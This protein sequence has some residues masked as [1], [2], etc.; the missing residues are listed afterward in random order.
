M[1][2]VNKDF[3]VKNGVV[4]GANIQ[5]VQLVSTTSSLPPL[6]VTSSANVVNLSADLLDG[7]HGSY[8]L[9][10]NNATNIPDPV[11]GLE[12]TG[13]VTGAA[14]V[15]LT[16]LANGQITLN[17]TIGPD[18]IVLGTDTQGN[19]IAG[20]SGGTGVSVSSSA[21]EGVITGIS[22]GQDVSTSADVS[23]NT[24]TST[25]TTTAPLVVS[26]SVIVTNLNA[27]YLDGYS[28]NDI[29]ASAGV[30][31]VTGTPN[32]INVSASTGNVQ[33]GLPDNVTIAGSLTIG[34]NLIVT[35]SSVTVHSTTV[36]IKDPIFTLGGES[37]PVVDDNKDRGI[38]FLYHDGVNAKQGFFGYDDSTGKFVFIP[39]ATNTS[40]VFSGTKGTID[41]NIEWSDVL[42]KP[43]PT[44]T[45]GGDLSG[46]VTLTDLGSGTL[47]AAVEKDFN[48]VF[49]GDVTGTGTVSNLNSASIALT[50][51]PDS[52]A[53]GT[54]TT[55]DYVA[56]LTGGDGITVTSG[57]GEGSTPTIAVNS[58][59]SVNWDN[60]N[61]KPSPIVG[62]NL[63]GDV[64]GAASA[65]LTALTNGQ[66]TISATIAPDSVAL[67]SDTT[68]SYVSLISGTA[69]QINVSGSGTEDAVVT[70]SLPQ[71]IA[72]T[73]TP[74]FAGVDL[75]EGRITSSSATV[76]INNTDTTIDTFTTT[77]F[78][79]A[80]YTIRAKQGTKMTTQKILV[81]W[82]GTDVSLSEYSIM[83][84]ATG[85]ANVTFT[86]SES[87]GTVSLTASS[88]DAASTNVIIKAVRIA[89]DA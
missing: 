72:T 64:T 81:M 37:A 7:Q 40:E 35:G 8:Y 2:T 58:S 78:T 86:A 29:L 27:D 15:T 23:F 39:D 16:N 88:P 36:N 43:D 1:A 55:G 38:E 26:S 83:D 60:V 3:V 30:Q 63:T 21:G 22:I 9:D 44:I 65:T 74:T 54:D 28:V 68:G 85:A 84:A 47:T 66:I 52:I 48:L 14:S 12:L 70:L 49:T 25:T 10:F 19:Y 82:D 4:A 59:A 89:I 56:T 77:T 42:N 75:P 6:T 53:L 73:S 33:V 87:G 80:E 62:V 57:T 5:G 71:D 50:I 46:N 20:I 13:D 45:L 61:N 41:A 79:S 67:G 69:N 17:T 24:I 18:S 51:Q 31:S 11:I 76:S 34:E 32:E